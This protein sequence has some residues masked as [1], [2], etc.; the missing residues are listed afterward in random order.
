M[1]PFRG[2]DNRSPPSLA[3]DPLQ[4]LCLDSVT[5]DGSG[6]MRVDVRYALRAYSCVA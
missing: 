2:G 6:S 4:S 1:D 5:N 3:E